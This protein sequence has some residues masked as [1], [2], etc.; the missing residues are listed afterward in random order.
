[1]TA[2]TN[3]TFVLAV[4]FE[5]ILQWIAKWDNTL[6]EHVP[7]SSVKCTQGRP[8][9]T[10]GRLPRLQHSEKA[11]RGSGSWGRGLPRAPNLVHSGKPFPSAVLPLGDDLMPS[12][13][14]LIFYIFFTLPRVQHSGKKFSFF[15]FRKR[16]P[17]VPYALT[18]GKLPLF[19]LNSLPRVP[20]P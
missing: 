4:L 20:L 2:N 1:M 18:L 7:S 10:R 11:Y 9:N 5:A 15:L 17:Q 16:L 6:R 3:S 19:F 8:Q 13:P 14:S 12:V